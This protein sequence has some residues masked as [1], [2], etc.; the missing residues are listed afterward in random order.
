MYKKNGASAPKIKES[1]LVLVQPRAMI[2]LAVART[3]RFALTDVKHQVVF[4]SRVGQK[5]PPYF[6]L[7]RDENCLTS[8]IFA[9]KAKRRQ[10]EADDFKLPVPLFPV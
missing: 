1:D 7:A 8:V 9:F 5:S 10:R 6:R 4:L 3:I 2:Q